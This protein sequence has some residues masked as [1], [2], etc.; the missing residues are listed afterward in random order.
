MISKLCAFQF[1]PNSGPRGGVGSN[2][3]LFPKLGVLGGF[4]LFVAAKNNC[5]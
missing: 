2:L 3:Y 5:Q 1:F 4:E